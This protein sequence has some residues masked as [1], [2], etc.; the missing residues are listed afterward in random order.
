MSSG[1][2]TRWQ[3]HRWE[4]HDYEPD[5]YDKY[6]SGSTFTTPPPIPQ[7]NV[8]LS[9]IASVYVWHWERLLACCPSFHSCTH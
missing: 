8:G 6:P 9:P 2:L 1:E 7:G 3:Y 4:Q 5:R